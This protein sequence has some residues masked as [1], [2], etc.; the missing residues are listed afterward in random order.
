MGLTIIYIIC[1]LLTFAWFKLRHYPLYICIAVAIFG[2][3]VLPFAYIIGD[4]KDY[5]KVKK[6][7]EANR[8]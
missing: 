5:N 4:V 7:D 8:T 1:G 2:M 6:D 3:V